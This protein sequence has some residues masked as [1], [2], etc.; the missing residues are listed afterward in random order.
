MIALAVLGKFFELS[1]DP[2][3]VASP[4]GYLLQ[5]N[6][7]FCNTL[8][9]ARETVLGRLFFEFLHADE[10]N[11]SRVR[12]AQ[13]LSGQA[14][15]SF[16]NRW[17]HAEGGFH[18]LEWNITAT[19]Q[20]GQCLLYGV[21]RE[22]EPHRVPRIQPRQQQAA[23]APQLGQ[24]DA[25][26][27][28]PD[29]NKRYVLTQAVQPQAR[30]R[31]REQYFRTIF[32]QAPIGIACFSLAGQWLE[33]N[34]RL[35]EMLGYEREV[36]R[37]MTLAEII[38]PEETQQETHYYDQLIRAAI[39]SCQFDKRLLR[40]DGNSL[41]TTVAVTALHNPE[42]QVHRFI[43]M[44][45]DISDR[46]THEL[47]RAERAHELRQLNTALARATGDLRRRNAELDQFAYVVSHDLKAPLRAL[48][49][50]A[51]WLAE[52]NADQLG[53]ESQRHLMLMQQRVTRMGGLLDGLLA[54]SRIG[55][56]NAAPKT[57][58]VRELLAELLDSLEIPAG[59]QIE[60]VEPMPSLVARE[61]SLS[62]VFS[63]LISNAIR[64]CDR[65]DGH[66]RI[67]A[68]ETAEAY[69]FTLADNGPGI[70]PAYHERI[71]EIFQTLQPRDH[72]ENAGVGLSIVQK[73]ITVEQGKIWLEP[74]PEVGATFHVSWPKTAIS[75]P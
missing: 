49:S 42:G 63:N 44:I 55:R 35:C 3:Y 39:A 9:Y 26:M 58:R 28:L 37:H 13:R 27:A 18:W 46:K 16:R 61:I 50:L 7:A 45:Q 34:D 41:W 5:V 75:P 53:E 38:H 2:L 54:Y 21:A 69:E 31:D 24:T 66:L 23:L 51:G 12:V 6:G 70:D 68:H 71:F 57:V 60:I 40:S 20:D 30:L 43:A 33:V 62:Q 47:E 72:S 4:E 73:I 67:S 52:D 14:G 64:Y 74:N 29:I 65:P 22:I 8:G 36:L 17:R 11:S 19:E 56:V 32:E 48:S 25:A 1:R 15:P 10:Q 59:F